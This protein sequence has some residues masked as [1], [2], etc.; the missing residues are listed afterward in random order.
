M[1]RGMFNKKISDSLEKMRSQE[2]KTRVAKRGLESC[3][4]GTWVMNPPR[5]DF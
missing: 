4:K 2:V 1:M 3:R 5:T